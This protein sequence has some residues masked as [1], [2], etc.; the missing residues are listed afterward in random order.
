[1]INVHLLYISIQFYFMFISFYQYIVLDYFLM[2]DFY[3]REYEDRDQINCEEES[4]HCFSSTFFST[5]RLRLS[6][7][8]PINKKGIKGPGLRSH[9]I[10]NPALNLSFVT[11]SRDLT[12]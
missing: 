4:I 5:E 6:Y 10:E 11:P 3:L 8:M 7:K 9:K 12:N 1:M 2:P